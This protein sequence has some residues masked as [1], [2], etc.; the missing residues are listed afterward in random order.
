MRIARLTAGLVPARARPAIIVLAMSAAAAL[1]GLVM[2]AF[3]DPIARV[4]INSALLL[5]VAAATIL[6]G[7]RG[8]AVVLVCS[9]VT[10][11]ILVL[12]PNGLLES[13]GP[14][15]ALLSLVGF[16]TV[17]VATIGLADRVRAQRRS[18]RTA[19]T[20]LRRHQAEREAVVV[21]T[22][23]AENART[24]LRM[25]SHELRTPLTT[26]QLGSSALAAAADLDAADRSTAELVLQ[27]SRRLDDLIENIT[28]MHRIE[29]GDL[30]TERN[31]FDLS[32]LVHD[33][34]D[35]IAARAPAN[36]RLEVR[37][38]PT[39]VYGDAVMLR[40]AVR[41]LVDNA[42]RHAVDVHNITVAVSDTPPTLSVMDDGVTSTTSQEGA[43]TVPSPTGRGGLGLGLSLVR[44]VTSAHGGSF[45]FGPRFPNGSVAQI[46]FPE[47]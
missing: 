41:N 35:D 8:G 40:I 27:E 42:V 46:R 5:P 19:L 28:S 15:S 11:E 30:C 25:V 4:G 3:D 37:A 21:A 2:A 39:S 18:L 6:V 7:R 12:P 1:I 44:A 22:A 29:S 34:V 16:T 47:P 38:A 10:T 26:I 45:E 36:V 13:D 33:V 17:G 14:R 32:A 23:R 24:L 9:V 20:D 31:P 43:A